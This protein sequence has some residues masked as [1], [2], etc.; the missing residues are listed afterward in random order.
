MV[1][2]LS[3]RRP[4]TALALLPQ[5]PRD[6][7]AGGGQRYLT[8]MAIEDRSAPDAYREKM[9]MTY[10]SLDALGRVTRE[11][12][13]EPGY[14]RPVR[15]DYNQTVDDNGNIVNVAA[16]LAAMPGCNS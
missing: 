12:S 5:Q 2:E 16:V 11:M 8:G 9:G 4:S 15:Y 7:D 14:G 13:G 6:V 1:R 3:T 10:R